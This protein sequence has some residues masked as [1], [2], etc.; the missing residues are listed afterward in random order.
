MWVKKFQE[1]FKVGF[2]FFDVYAQCTK[3]VH[4]VKQCVS[5]TSGK[6]IEARKDD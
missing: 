4:G 6:G 1:S 2:I 3:I 5:F